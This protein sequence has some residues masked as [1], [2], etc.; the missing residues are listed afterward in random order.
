MTVHLAAFKDEVRMKLNGQTASE[1]VVAHPGEHLWARYLGC[2][3][4]A[5]CG[6]IRSRGPMPAARP[7]RGIV[8]LG[9]R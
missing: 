6:V 4:C 9:L 8:R 7:C 2:E 3:M 1:Y 5:F